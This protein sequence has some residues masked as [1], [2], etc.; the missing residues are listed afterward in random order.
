MKRILVT[1]TVLFALAVS[2][3]TAD[4]QLYRKWYGSNYYGY[5]TPY[6]S[7]GTGYYG[8]PYAYS[9]Y[10]SYYYPGTMYATP[11]YASSY[12]TPT[13]YSFPG[14]TYSSYYGT[15]TASFYAPSYSPYGAYYGGSGTFMKTPYYYYGY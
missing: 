6:S 13:A 8:S 10:S 7:Y 12:Y 4:A 14:Y 11:Y 5:G 15:P 2:V 9:A 3:N 1:L